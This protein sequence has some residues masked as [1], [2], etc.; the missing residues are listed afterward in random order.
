MKRIFALILALVLVCGTAQVTHAKAPAK[1]DETN[2]IS[3]V[4]VYTY[5]EAVDRLV[6]KLC[7]TESEARSMLGPDKNIELANSTMSKDIDGVVALASSGY[8]FQEFIFTDSFGLGMGVEYGTLAEM[9]YYNQYRQIDSIV[10]KWYGP[11]SSGAYT[12]TN[13]YHVDNCSPPDYDFTDQGRSM[14]EIAIQFSGQLEMEAGID[15]Y[16][17]A[18]YSYSISGSFTVFFRKT[19]TGSHYFS[20]Y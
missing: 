10:T 2:S 16:V 13:F 17:T 8:Y 14:V 4:N 12:V 7:I 19:Q 9:Y 3:Q 15:I 11:A 6:E 18:G 5:E 20:I 1:T